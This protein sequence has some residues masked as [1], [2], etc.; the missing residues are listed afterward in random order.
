MKKD[1]IDVST[2]ICAGDF[3]SF[4]YSSKGNFYCW[5]S[6]QNG[7]FG[8]GNNDIYNGIIK[9]TL[10]NEKIFQMRSKGNQNVILLDSGKVLFWPFEKKSEKII[11][12][13][14][15][16][17]TVEKISSVSCGENFSM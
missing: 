6:N 15:E 3:H 8:V 12:H 16:L 17:P 13:P 4:S 5:G 2:S 1:D 7:E 9:N 10:L 14:I 11:Y